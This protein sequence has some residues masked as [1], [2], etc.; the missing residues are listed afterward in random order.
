MA[1]SDDDDLQIEMIGDE[2]KTISFDINENKIKRVCII[3][4]DKSYTIESTQVK[5]SNDSIKEQNQQP[6]VLYPHDAEQILKELDPNI[7]V[8]T[9]YLT[10]N[11]RQSIGIIR[12]LKH[13]VDIFINLYDNVDETA[14]K[15]IEYMQ[16]EGIAFTGASFPF[17]DPT[18]IELKRLCRYNQLLTPK[19]A[20]I[21]DLDKYNDDTLNQVA[22][23]LGGFPLFVKPEH[24]YDSVGINEKSL[25][26]NVTDMKQRCSPVIDEF[27]GA[28]IEQHIEGREFTVLVIGSKEDIF[29]FPPVEYH[30]VDKKTFITFEDKWG[31]N[32]TKSHWQLLDGKEQELID[33]LILL[34]KQMYQ[35]FNGDGYARMDIRQDQRTKQLFILDCNPNCSIFYRD[36]CSADFICQVNGWSK[37]R[38]MKFLLDQGLKRQREYHLKHSYII[39]YSTKYGYG[40]YASRDLLTGDVV[41]SYENSMIKLITKQYAQQTFNQREMVA[42]NDYAWPL[43][44]NV[45]VLWH[46]DSA[47]WQPINHSCDPNVWVD[48]L[49]Y[50]ARRPIHDDEQLTVDYSTYTVSSHDFECW[51]KSPLCRRRIQPNEYK[52]KWFQDRYGSHTTSYTQMLIEIDK[53]KNNKL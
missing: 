53:M 32:Y 52:E 46:E 19:F 17:N 51:C 37:S 42:F 41:Y 50:V 12:R 36:S 6:D 34:A 27:G 8:Q 5:H 4:I 44:E 35:A 47:Q 30:F 40:M 24:G 9:I 26:C 3:N 33:D 38:L 45:Y 13:D 28:L 39:K 43:C 16:N 18:R 7:I 1:K 15:I 14:N 48:G 21:I 20:L 11:A 23:K 2:R 29:V 49:Q 22:N 31:S 25:V 10:P